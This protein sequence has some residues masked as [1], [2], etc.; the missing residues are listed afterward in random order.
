MS[1]AKPRKKD[2]LDLFL[3]SK[4]NEAEATFQRPADE[5]SRGGYSTMSSMQKRKKKKSTKQISPKGKKTS[6]SANSLGIFL[7]QQPK[8]KQD[9]EVRSAY[10][11]MDKA[12][13]NAFAGDAPP[14]PQTKAELILLLRKAKASP[15]K[16][17]KGRKK[18]NSS[19]NSS[20]LNSSSGSLKAVPEEGE[21][22]SEEG[23]ERG[24]ESP[25][26]KNTSIAAQRTMTLRRPTGGTQKPLDDAPWESQP[27]ETTA[28]ASMESPPQSPP[29]S[30]SPHQA[31]QRSHQHIQRRMSNGGAMPIHRRMSNS[32][33]MPISLVS[34][35][36]LQTKYARRG[37]IQN[38]V[39]STPRLSNV[40]QN[41]V[42]R[43]GL[44]MTPGLDSKHN[45]SHSHHQQHH[46][47]PDDNIRL[48]DDIF[49]YYSWSDATTGAQGNSTSKLARKRLQDS[50][51]DNPLH[52][53]LASMEVV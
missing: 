38:S 23:S 40:S 17:K 14:I 46:K 53:A 1:S 34:K 7:D 10:T 31:I 19:N 25:Q 4:Q 3:E 41:R 20:K 5:R 44:P 26:I 8:D 15:D 22:A 18:R 32:G 37:S 6:F 49:T 47:H 45:R 29:L 13:K 12:R 16:K 51:K 48:D 2:K 9:I 11:S 42:K 36:Q 50:L 33:A 27:T 43:A 52:R 24:P 21:L 30:S 28:S 35:Q 39:E